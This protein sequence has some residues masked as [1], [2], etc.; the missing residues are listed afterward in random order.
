MDR[1][2]SVSRNNWL[3]ADKVHRQDCEEDTA[4]FE[5][6]HLV[7]TFC[8]SCSPAAMALKSMI[9]ALAFI[10]CSYT[11]APFAA[12]VYNGRFYTILKYEV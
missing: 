1:V 8:T 6:A 12:A 9:S 7:S 11:R 3:F 10:A 2:G 5:A 4:L